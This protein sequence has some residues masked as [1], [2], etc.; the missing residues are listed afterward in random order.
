MVFSKYVI[1]R[2][3]AI[4]GVPTSGQ[5]LTWNNTTKSYEPTE[6][7]AAEIPV[8]G[9]EIPATNDPT[10]K[11]TVKVKDDLSA[12]R[13]YELPNKNGTI[14]VDSDIQVMVEA[15]L[16]SNTLLTDDLYAELLSL[17]LPTDGSWRLEYN[18]IVGT[19]AD[20]VPVTNAQLC[21]EMALELSG[22]YMDEDDGSQFESIISTGTHFALYRALPTDGS[23]AGFFSDLASGP[24]NMIDMTTGA[25]VYNGRDGQHHQLLSE[26]G[27]YKLFATII[28]AEITDGDLYLL[29]G[30]SIRATRKTGAM[31]L[32]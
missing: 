29:A 16:S 31:S 3:L 12:N 28:P 23:R 20:F 9:I 6:P 17:S 27:T 11:G 19:S 2:L 18:L 7:A 25:T 21:V 10:K 13:T 15:V 4:L 1:D 24:I 26:A 14:V 5:V 22:L 32:P 30:S 8:T